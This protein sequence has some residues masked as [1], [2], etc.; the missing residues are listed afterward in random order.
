MDAYS[1]LDFFVIVESGYKAPFIESLDWLERPRPIAYRFQNTP[2]GYK[3]LYDDGIFCE[4]AVFE[5]LEMTDIPYASGRVVWHVG[6]FDETILTPPRRTRPESP[7]DWL[8]GE[9]LT[10]LYV[11]LGRLWRGETLSATRFIQG[12]AVDRV[13]DLTRHIETPA[14]VYAD[15]FGNERRF[16][17][18]FPG[19]TAHLADFL[20]G[21]ERNVESARAILNWLDQHFEV[22]PAMKAAITRLFEPAPSDA[23]PDETRGT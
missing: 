11:G 3:A 18:R 2:D 21:Y 15:Q 19:T 12:H 6:G 23:S 16:E 13:A 8:L 14:P 17:R 10:N 1:D 22:H 7:S 9:A 4:F 20:Q 5:P